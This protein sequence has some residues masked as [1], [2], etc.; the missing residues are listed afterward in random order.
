MAGSGFMFNRFQR[1]FV[2]IILV[3]GLF[4]RFFSLHLLS[5]P[6]NFSFSKRNMQV[7][8]GFELSQNFTP[9]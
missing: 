4:M 9:Y 8:E 1:E 7:K 3:C 6:F 5:D 2:E